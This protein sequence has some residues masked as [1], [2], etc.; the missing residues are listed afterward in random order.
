[1]KSKLLVFAVFIF[2]I[3]SY[4][5]EFELGTIITKHYD[6]ITDVKIEKNS[7][8]KSLLQIVYI[9]KDGNTQKPDIESIKC[10]TRGDEKFVRIYYDC[11]MILVKQLVSGRKVN[12][13]QRDYNGITAYYVEKVFD[14]LIKVPSSSNKFAK[15]LSEFLNS[16]AQI[17]EQVK[18]KKLTDIKEI[19]TLYNEG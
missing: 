14:E 10:Y 9:D 7:D 11:E 15:E 2:T 16:N 17:S 19:V 8:Y 18:D 3:S 12:L 13:Y 1:M 6:T 4:S 5:Q